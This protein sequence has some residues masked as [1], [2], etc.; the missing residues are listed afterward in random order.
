MFT[1]RSL[2]ILLSGVIRMCHDYLILHQELHV[3]YY[4]MRIRLGPV[5]MHRFS[6]FIPR[7]PQITINNVLLINQS[8]LGGN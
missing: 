1:P 4:H 6:D 3:I 2:Y 8:Q 5:L 7:I